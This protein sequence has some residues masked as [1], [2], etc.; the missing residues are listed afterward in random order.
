M[1]SL[2]HAVRQMVTATERLRSSL[3]LLFHNLIL[4]AMPILTFDKV[5]KIISTI[6]AIL[7]Y[8]IKLFTG[9]DVPADDE[10]AE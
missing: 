10:K 1:I 7:S 6:L 3:A 4:S 5:L 8:A 9:E 2:C